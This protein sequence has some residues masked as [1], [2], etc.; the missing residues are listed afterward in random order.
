MGDMIVAAL[1]RNP[2]FI[3]AALPAA[4]VPP[5]VQLLPARA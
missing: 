3:S 2:L 4:R 1:E 5:A